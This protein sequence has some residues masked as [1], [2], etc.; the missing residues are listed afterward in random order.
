MRI[1]KGVFLPGLILIFLGLFILLE[2]INVINGYFILPFIGVFL[3]IL[4]FAYKRSGFFISGIILLFLGIG[5]VAATIPALQSVPESSM[6]LLFFGLSFLFIHIFE[7]K[8]YGNWPL[9]IGLIIIAIAVLVYLVKNNIIDYNVINA[10]QI[11]WPALL[12]VFGA[13]VIIRGILKKR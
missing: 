9:I 8:R 2:K 3:I 5:E 6:V 10:I 12:I 4:Y 7:Y 1:E 13:V 11:Y